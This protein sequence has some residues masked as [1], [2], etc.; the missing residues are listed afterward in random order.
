MKMR[1]L[2]KGAA[3]V[4]YDLAMKG[5]YKAS[6]CPRE[7]MPRRLGL[8]GRPVAGGLLPGDPAGRKVRPGLP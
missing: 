5:T 3:L 4:T 6:R 1:M 7:A 8:S 2:A